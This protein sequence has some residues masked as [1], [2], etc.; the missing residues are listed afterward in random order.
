MSPQADVE[1][2][3]TP[4]YPLGGADSPQGQE[5][6]T[7][8]GVQTCD[9]PGCDEP[10]KPGANKQ[11]RFCCAA[12]KAEYWHIAAQIGDRELRKIAGGSQAKKVYELLKTRA[13]KWTPRPTAPVFRDAV[14]KL[15]RRG[16]KIECQRGFNGVLG[17]TQYEYKLSE[18]K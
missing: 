14:T 17:R 3:L 11:G 4:Q 1:C 7:V 13:G 2:F 15:R 12:H 18:A 10:P 5:T 8:Y 16:H 9:L 6:H